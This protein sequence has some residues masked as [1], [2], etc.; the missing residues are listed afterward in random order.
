MLKARPPLAN[1]REIVQGLVTT[2]L[3]QS[4]PRAF[5]ASARAPD[6]GLSEVSVFAWQEVAAAGA[7][8]DFW[9]AQLGMVETDLL[10]TSARV[11]V[12]WS[13]ACLRRTRHSQLSKSTRAIA[14]Y[15]GIYV[16]KDGS[17]SEAYLHRESRLSAILAAICSK[18][19]IGSVAL[20]DVGSCGLSSLDWADII[21]LLKQSYKTVVCVDYAIPEL[22]SLGAGFQDLGRPTDRVS[23]SGLMA[24]DR[25]EMVSDDLL[26]PDPIVSYEQRATLYTAYMSELINEFSAG[27]N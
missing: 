22:T 9:T 6:E 5:A 12:K 27:R 23:R 19:S 3:A 25:W 7:S 16:R 8:I 17:N 13:D 20:V 18:A 2:I 11:I 24:C 10:P 21:P 4:T 15:Y 26:S 1:R 14:E